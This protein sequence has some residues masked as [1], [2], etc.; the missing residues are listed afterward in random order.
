MKKY[1]INFL[2]I[3]K[4]DNIKLKNMILSNL[5]FQKLSDENLNNLHNKLNIDKNIILS[6]RNQLLK[7]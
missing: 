6:Y 1:T 2:K 7:N 3:L 4:R 5:S